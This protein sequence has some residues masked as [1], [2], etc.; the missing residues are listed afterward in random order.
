MKK[1]L[2]RFFLVLLFVP[3]TLAGAVW[4]GVLTAWEVVYESPEDFKRIW[5]KP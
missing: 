3:L 4:Y 2:R 5:N 1:Y